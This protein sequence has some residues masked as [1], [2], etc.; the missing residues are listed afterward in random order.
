M[1]IM[2]NVDGY[3]NADQQAIRSF[4]LK[5]PLTC[6]LVHFTASSR[7]IAIPWD[8]RFGNRFLRVL[9]ICVSVS[10][11]LL[12]SLVPSDSSESADAS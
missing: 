5:I 12:R 9:A 3:V 1:A 4:S 7:G 2:L 8:W 6:G 10:S 11:A